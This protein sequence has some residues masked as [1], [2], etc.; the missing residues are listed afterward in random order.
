MISTI[1]GIKADIRD[2]QERIVTKVFQN[3]EKGVGSIMV[4]SPTGSGK[5]LMGLAN[6]RTMQDKLNVGWGWVAMRR[7][8]LSQTEEMNQRLNVGAELTYISM[9]QKD[10]PMVDR[11][12]RPIVGVTLDECQHDATASMAAIH[13]HLRPQYIVGLSATPYRTDR[14]KLCFQKVIRDIGIHQLISQGYLA[15]YHHYTV[16]EFTVDSVVETYLREPQRWG[17]SIFYWLTEIEAAACVA[18]LRAG[19]ITAELVTA[20]TDRDQQIADFKAGKT[21]CLVNMQVLTEGFD[22]D[23]LNSVFVRDS[24]RGPTIQMA[25]RVFRKHADIPHKNVIQS[26]HSHWPMVK[27]ASPIKAHV[28]MDGGWRE[29][30]NSQISETVAANSTMA[31]ANTQTTFPAWL[32]NKLIKTARR[33]RG[34]R[35]GN[36]GGRHNI[37]HHG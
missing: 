27:T 2:Y 14:V 6:V 20:N 13:N 5:T 31:L 37:M 28:W 4:Q 8:L 7:N 26:K 23:I 15:P 29:L 18:G 21:T 9:F 12:G 32:T 35:G 17:K 11:W 1:P 36:T 33:G 10:I 16:P 3:F 25:G 19:G 22:C 24:Q 34:G 30:G